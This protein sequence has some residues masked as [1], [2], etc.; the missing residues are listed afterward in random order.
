MQ[1]D[2]IRVSLDSKQPQFG[3]LYF[4]S[5]PSFLTLE[6]PNLDNQSNISCI[7]KGGYTCK[8]VFDRILPNGN[9]IDVTFEVLN[10][11]NRQG[12]LFHT[13]NTVD[14]TRGCILIGSELGELGPKKAIRQS[15]LAFQK[16]LTLL[17]DIT[18]FELN[19]TEI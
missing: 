17:Q 16:F 10:V 14:D 12:I 7:P 8:K 4:G 9:E 5:T 18:Q 13:G 1:L 15:K 11:P 19:I 2:L 6:P 3:L